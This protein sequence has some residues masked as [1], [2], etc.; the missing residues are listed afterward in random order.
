MTRN[1][2]GVLALLLCLVGCADT[3]ASNAERGTSGTS[4]S[5]P[6]TATRGLT[7]DE[8][9]AIAGLEETLLSSDDE[10]HV[11]NAACLAT[12]YVESLGIEWLQKHGMVRRDLGGK[13]GYT[14]D[15]MTEHDAN[16]YYDVVFACVSYESVVASMVGGEEETT[17][18]PEVVRCVK[19]V[20]EEEVKEAFVAGASDQEFHSTPFAKK[21]EAQGCGYEGD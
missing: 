17:T 18:D 6:S 5:D 12:G 1:L 15:V 13:Q 9:A 21:L 4:R 3:S 8:T 20:T 11:S 7:T 19:A 2:V 14:D 10:L 16:V